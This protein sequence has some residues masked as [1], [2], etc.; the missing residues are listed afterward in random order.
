MLWMPR[1]EHLYAATFGRCGAAGPSWPSRR[2]REE[3]DTVVVSLALCVL[4]LT[5]SSADGFRWLNHNKRDD[6]LQDGCP[7]SG[8]C[9]ST[10]GIGGDP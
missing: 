10:M 3:R 8:A 9:R 4:L 6:A 2:A 1:P 5:A 7:C